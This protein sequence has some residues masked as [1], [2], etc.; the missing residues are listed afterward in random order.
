MPFFY[1]ISIRLFALAIG[2]AALFHRKARLWKKGRKKWR[3]NLKQNIPSNR[4]IIWFHCASLGEFEQGRPIMEAIQKETPDIFLLITFFSPSGYEIRKNTPIAGHVCYLPLDTKKNA[5]DFINIVR[6]ETAF[7][8]KYEFWFHYLNALQQAEI[9][10]YFI[11]SSFRPNQYF[12]KSTGR[13]THPY[14]RKITRFFV[15]NQQSKTL[16]ENIGVTHITVSGDTRFDRTAKLAENPQTLPLIK[17]FK[18]SNRLLIGGST[19][20]PEE[21]LLF[22]LSK[23]NISDLKII[24]APHDVSESRF[25]AIEKL[26]EGNCLRFSRANS[27]NVDKADVLIIDSIGLLNKIY[28]HADI[29]FVGGA[30]GSGLHNILE[31]LT[32]GVPVFFGPKTKKFPEAQQA[33]TAGC[34]LQISDEI[35]FVREIKALLDSPENLQSC[36]QKSRNFIRNNA[37]ATEIIMQEWN[38]FKAKDHINKNPFFPEDS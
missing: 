9:P 14:L 3:K 23:E 15:Q 12:F 4:Q 10:T 7:F 38:L 5:F 31:A 32:Y 33:I 25:Q 37:G 28:Y 6:P 34:G 24:I 17:K 11:S 20:Q 35:T 26:F 22:A 2:I 19:W 13:W 30:F 8:V 18:G 21:S 27:E 36:R 1:S 16:L 29:A